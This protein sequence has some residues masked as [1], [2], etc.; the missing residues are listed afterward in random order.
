MGTEIKLLNRNPELKQQ[1][2][3][4]KCFHAALML[5]PRVTV[6]LAVGHAMP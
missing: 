3:S 6:S 5:T 4:A 2:G 1:K